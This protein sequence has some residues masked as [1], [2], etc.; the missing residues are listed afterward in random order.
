MKY[1]IKFCNRLEEKDQLSV[2]VNVV[3]DNSSSSAQIMEVRDK[4][5]RIIETINKMV[6][7]KSQGPVTNLY[8]VYETCV[9]VNLP[10]S[11]RLRP[12]FGID[13]PRGSF[14]SP[15]RFKCFFF[16]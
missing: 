8:C 6:S 2:V 7:Y 4:P 16:K 15:K 5:S 10:E 1:M 11:D 13:S 3:N 9:R 12:K 14:G